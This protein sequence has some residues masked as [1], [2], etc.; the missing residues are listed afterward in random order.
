MKQYDKN[1]L[2]GFILMAIILI[3]FNTFFLPEIEEDNIKISNNSINQNTEENKTVSN[4]DIANKEIKINDD[5]NINNTEKFHK[6]SIV[7]EKYEIIENEKIKALVSNKGGQIKSVILKQFQTYDSLELNLFN[8]DS[9]LFNLKF[10][11]AS[12]INTSDLFF[13]AYN[14]GSNLKMRYELEENKFIEYIY[15]ISDNYVIDFKIN[16][17][18]LDELIPSSINYMNLEWSMITPK[19][20]KS[21][22]NQD[23][24][25]GIYYQY[26]SDKETD[27]LSLTSEEDEDEVNSKLKWVAFKQQFFSSII[28]SKE[29]FGKPS[30]LLSKKSENKKSI[31]N[32]YCKFELPFEHKKN[33]QYN[34]QFYFGPNHFKTLEQ[35]DLGFEEILPLGWGIFGWVNKFVI[36]NIFDFLSKYFTN[37]GLIILIL[38]IIIKLALAPFTYK[39]Y[40]SQA[41]MKV[42]KP[43]IDKINEKLKGKDP[44][45]IQQETMGLYRK[46]GVNPMG[47]CLPMLFQFPILIAM[48]RF[49]P[50][51]IELRQKKFLWADDLSSYDSIM[52]LPFEIPFYGDHVSLFTLLMTISTLLYTRMNSSMAT[53]QMAQMKW[54]M[55]LMP[56][57]FLGFF[58]NYA[59]GLSYYYFLAN[60]FT[61]SQQFFM[62][63]FIDENKILAEI[64]KNKKNP[65]K[66]SKF[67][68]KLEEIQ[69]KQAEQMKKRR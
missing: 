13:K 41:K 60:M 31:K 56:I 27:N 68:K 1:S 61:F 34:F 26:L 64:E 29:G 50:A 57:M 38:T 11:T 44:M 10:I 49:F 69:R 30:Y 53:G 15:T 6:S 47:G 45:K 32:L 67:Q 52:N 25:T 18:G 2:I 51:S 24:Y 58:N 17:I 43:E 14:D 62:K 39:A 63:K 4:L 9:C 46:A 19:T 8:I 12:S 55:Y 7:E 59:A 54:M 35:Y 36:I 28:I 23:M 5:E 37:Y 65:K 33:E 42:L 3:V 40:L 22:S 20:E 48:F 21:K 16:L 66:K